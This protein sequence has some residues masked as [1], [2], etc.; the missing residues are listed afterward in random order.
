MRWAGHVACVGEKRNACRVLV[1]KPEGKRRLGRPR[2]R[3]EDNIK[4]NL[5]E[6]R[7]F[8]AN[9]H[10]I[11]GHDYLLRH[12]NGIGRKDSPMC[13]LSDD[14][15]EV[16]LGHIQKC[17]SLTDNMDNAN[18]RDKW[19]NVSKLYCTAIKE[20]GDIRITGVG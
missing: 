6:L 12:L 4:M 5:K 15:E 11:T 20:M 2:H 1:M 13:P 9:F 8:A 17:Q 3:W 19:W 10:L 14:T 7:V 18:N 16:D